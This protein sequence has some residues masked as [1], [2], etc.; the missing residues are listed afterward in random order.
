MTINTD[1]IIVL[2]IQ[3]PNIDC[4]Y[5]SKLNFWTKNLAPPFP[6]KY[7]VDIR[8]NGHEEDLTPVCSKILEC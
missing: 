8:A 4:S 3:L 1:R 6:G 5:L 7:T 2:G